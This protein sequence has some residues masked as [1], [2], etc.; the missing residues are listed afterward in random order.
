ME[1]EITGE[2]VV[3]TTT[4]ETIASSPVQGVEIFTSEHEAYLCLMPKQGPAVTIHFRESSEDPMSHE[5][6]AF[7]PGAETV[8]AGIEAA[9]E[10]AYNWDKE[11]TL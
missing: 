6:R 11:A 10:A 8:L 2:I 1:M 3:K 4:T 9:I 7:K 5:P